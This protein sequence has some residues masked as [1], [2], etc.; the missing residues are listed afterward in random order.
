MSNLAAGAIRSKTPSQ[1]FS[2]WAWE[3]VSRLHLHALDQE[4]AVNVQ[5]SLT[6]Q[7]VL[8]LDL[9]PLM[10]R[11]VSG[12]VA[13]NPMAC[14]LALQ[15]SQ[16]GHCLNDVVERGFGQLKLPAQSGHYDHVSLPAIDIKLNAL[17]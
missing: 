4:V 9:N 5:D 3:T 10:D 16:T 6:D 11:V 1:Q 15:L 2:S 14:Y 17:F 7:D 12:V 8:D 13:K